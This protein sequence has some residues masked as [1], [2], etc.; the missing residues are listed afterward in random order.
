M[1]LIFFQFLSYP[2]TFGLQ[3]VHFCLNT[4]GHLARFLSRFF[5]VGFTVGNGHIQLIDLV[6]QLEDFIRE[7]GIGLLVGLDLVAELLVFAVG[8]GAVPFRFEILDTGF[9]FTQL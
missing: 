7:D 3:V 1:A 4:F 5:Q 9:P 2:L 6:E 8:T